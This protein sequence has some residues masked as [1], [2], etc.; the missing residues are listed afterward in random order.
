MNVTVPRAELV[1]RNISCLMRGF[2]LLPPATKYFNVAKV[3]LSSSS[4]LLFIT[5]CCLGSSHKPCQWSPISPG[6]TKSLARQDWM[7]RQFDNVRWNAC[8]IIDAIRIHTD[9]HT[10]V[11]YPSSEIDP[12][13]G[14]VT[15]SGEIAPG[16]GAKVLVDFTPDSLGEY[17]D[18]ISVV[19]EVGTFEVRRG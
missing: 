16:V 7:A 8:F 10:Q 5:W 14:M 2:I 9:E 3:V 6:R 15:G 18:I 13:S 1:L 19:T 17:H 4:L 11:V 12:E